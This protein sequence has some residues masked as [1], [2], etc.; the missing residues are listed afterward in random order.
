MVCVVIS[1][2]SCYSCFLALF[3]HWN[4]NEKMAFPFLYIIT[5]LVNWI[6]YGNNLGGK[7]TRPVVI[8]ELYLGCLL[9]AVRKE[10][11]FCFC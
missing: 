4:V 5:N 1:T 6:T 2:F 11:T 7:N 3:T 8:V 9:N 10:I